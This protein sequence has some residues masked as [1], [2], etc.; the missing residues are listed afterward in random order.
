[1]DES[2]YVEVISLIKIILHNAKKSYAIDR[3]IALADEA[4]VD[5]AEYITT[6]S[7]M[8][9]AHTG[10]NHQPQPT[11]FRVVTKPGTLGV[12]FDT[13]L[14]NGWTCANCIDADHPNGQEKALEVLRG[15]DKN[16]GD[17][18]DFRNQTIA[19]LTQKRANYYSFLERKFGE[20]ARKQPR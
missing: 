16:G 9:I 1:M 5:D 12:T 15:I 4:G 19:T 7:Q 10:T 6:A 18:S 11:K 20:W 2:T 8:L 3:L 14:A 13:W 17:A